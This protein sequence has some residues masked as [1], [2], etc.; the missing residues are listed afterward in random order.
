MDRS[1]IHDYSVTSH[2]KKKIKGPR[3]PSEQADKQ[4]KSGEGLHFPFKG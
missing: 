3:F 4:K 2:R 1:I